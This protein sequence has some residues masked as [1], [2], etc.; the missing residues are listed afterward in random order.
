MSTLAEPRSSKATFELAPYKSLDNATLQARI[1]AVRRELG[2]RLLVLGHH[3][4]QD[5]VIAL[6]DLRGDSYQLSQMAAA[7]RDCRAIAFCGVHFMAETADILANTPAKLAERDG[8]RVTVVLPDL[9]AGCSMADMAMIEQVEACWEDLGQT[10][11]TEQV[12]PVTY[13]NS[14]ASLKAFCGRHG[15]IVCTSSNAAAAVRWAFERGQR[16]LFFP[17]QHLG[18]NT[19]K[20]M[21][22]PLAAMRVWDPHQELGGNDEAA[23]EHSRVLLWK[24]H[25]SVHQM[26]R[27]EHVDQFRAKYPGIRILVHP[28]CT[29]EVVDKS[30][31]SGSTGAIIRAVEAAPPGTRWAIGTELHLVNRLKQEHPEQEIHFLSPVVC[32]C[33]TMYRI[34][35]AHLCWSL[36]NLA[37]GTPVNVIHVDDD[38]ARWALVALERMLE[39]R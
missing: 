1:N 26:F 5:E 38:T 7:S 21:G 35:L 6:S 13:I 11:D 28:E 33:A 36:D 24:G 8:Q 12:I 4:Q 14:A 10:V 31:V 25:C 39:I 16:V 37:A 18:R 17:D 20:A 23:I 9:A 22:I 2:P 34:D 30:D 32:M 19:A 15:G 27:T 29:M 3:Y